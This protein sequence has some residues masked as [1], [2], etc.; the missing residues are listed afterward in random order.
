MKMYINILDKYK[1][2]PSPL[3]LKQREL[4]LYH[5]YLLYFEKEEPT[6]SEELS[7]E[8][9]KNQFDLDL[10]DYFIEF[11]TKNQELNDKRILDL[12]ASRRYMIITI[13]FIALME[14]ISVINN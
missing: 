10:L 7:I 13:I 1:Y 6:K 5:H 14:I 3:K 2:L 11:G 9:S 4:E 8:A 12:Y